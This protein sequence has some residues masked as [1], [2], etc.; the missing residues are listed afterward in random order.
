MAVVS[1][2]DFR[3]YRGVHIKAGVMWQLCQ[4]SILQ[5]MYRGEHNMKGAWQSQKPLG[6]LVSPNPSTTF[7]AFIFC[8]LHYF[9]ISLWT[10]RPVQRL[11]ALPGPFHIKW[12]E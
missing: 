11:L 2:F 5:Y 12:Q 7:D 4:I 9:L 3:I 1:N 6:R 10:R 8:P